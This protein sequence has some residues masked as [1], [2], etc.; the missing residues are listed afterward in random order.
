M[1]VLQ[2]YIGEDIVNC[3]LQCLIDEWVFLFEFYVIMFDF[4]CILCEEVGLEW[5]SVIIDFFEWIILFDLQVI[6]VMVIQ[7]ED[8]CWDVVIDVEVCKYEV[9]GEG[10]QIEE[11]IDYFI[12]IGVFMCDFEG[13]IEG[14]DYVFYMEKYCVDENMMWFELIVDEELFY[15]GIDLYNKLV[16]CNFDD[17]L[18]C[19]M[20]E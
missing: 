12:D 1:Y 6:D 14:F 18:F 19:V 7:C 15:V 3:V 9:D 16:D 13:V 5:D 20:I 8:G 2:D 17:N 11:D 10:Q 4:L